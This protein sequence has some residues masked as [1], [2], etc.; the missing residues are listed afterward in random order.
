M[1]PHGRQQLFRG[2]WA[3]VQG[4]EMAVEE[5]WWS[6]GVEGEGAASWGWVGTGGSLV[7]QCSPLWLSDHDIASS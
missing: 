5:G 7:V 6:H 3:R 2:S 1:G 4:E